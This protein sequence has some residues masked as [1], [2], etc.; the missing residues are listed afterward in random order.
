M[1]C[2]RLRGWVRVRPPTEAEAALLA[3]FVVEHAPRCFVCDN[4][5]VGRSVGDGEHTCGSLACQTVREC[6]VCAWATNDLAAVVGCAQCL[7]CDTMRDVVRRVEPSP[8][9]PAV[10]WAVEVLK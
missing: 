6:S 9:T 7:R 1:H 3:S 10:R 8:W 2:A 5:A 4:L